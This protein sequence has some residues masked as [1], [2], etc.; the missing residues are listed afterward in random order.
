VRSRSWRNLAIA[1]VGALA[2]GV[3]MS[4]F[5]GNNGGDVREAIG[6]L[7]APWLLLPFIAGASAT[8]GRI[9]LAALVGAMVSFLALGGFYVANSFVLHLGPHPWLD[10]L[11]LAFG[12]GYFFK[13][14][15]LSGP[16]FGALGAWWRQTRS[17]PLGLLVAALFV[18]EPFAWT[19]YY[20]SAY[21]SDEP[22]WAAEVVVGVAACAVVW[23]TRQR[24][25]P[26]S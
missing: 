4:L 24:R 8:A 23:R 2:F 26:A 21:T 20:G 3:G 22:V 1:A 5:K 16:A 6:N 9:G 14:A 12:N 17:R 7:S 10:D 15:L 13:F 18:F 11:R 25:P 19:A